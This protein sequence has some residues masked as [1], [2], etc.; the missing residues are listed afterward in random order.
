MAKKRQ[1]KAS[2]DTLFVSDLHAPYEHP[3]ALTFLAALKK[4]YKFS[5]IICVGDELDWHSLSYH[6][7]NPDLSSA[8]DELE[9][10]RKVMHALWR[11]FP[12]MD[13]IE[14]NHGALVFRK[15]LTNGMPLGVLPSYKEIIFG[16]RDSSRNLRGR[17][18]GTGW[19]WHS[20][21]ILD[22]G[23]GHKCLVVHGDG[24]SANALKNVKEAGMSYCSGH[25]HSTFDLQF[26]GTSEFLH[27]G[28]IIGCMIDP[29]SI[30]FDYGKKR[31]MKRP[32]LGCG[33]IVDGH[34]RLFPMQLGK[35]G[36][37]NG[38]TP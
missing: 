16:D 9:K 15:A 26:H 25:W 20:K 23:D 18:I 19:R 28:L 7:K 22:L 5:R 11:L 30:A 32:I 8:G 33:G 21:L 6:D 13:I 12:V 36:R 3:D 4:K 2:K 29:H 35:D 24:S 37:W 31:I 34:P 1:H 27:F 17:T 38:I 10:S 14:S